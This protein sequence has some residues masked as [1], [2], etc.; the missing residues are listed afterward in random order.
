MDKMGIRRDDIRLRIGAFGAE[1]WTEDMRR[2]IE[3]RL[4]LQGYNLYGL[5]E[6]MGLCVS[7]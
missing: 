5:S 2:E 7:Y 1:P 6:I 3:A 4:G